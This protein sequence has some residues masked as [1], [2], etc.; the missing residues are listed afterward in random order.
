MFKKTTSLLL[1]IFL[2]FTIQAQI[3]A[4]GIAV[5]DNLE[6]FTFTDNGNK[7]SA[8]NPKTCDVDTVEFPRYKASSLVTISVSGGRSLGQLYSCPKPLTL[9]GFTFYAFVLPNPPTA[10]KMNLICRV[11][12]AGPDSLPRG[13][14]LRAD[15][16]TI[17][18]TLGG[19]V[20]TKIE[21]H[22]NW[23]AIVL[24]SNYI[25]TVETDSLNMTAG[26][27]TNNYANGDGDR[28]N[29]NCGSI[30]GLWY[31]GRNLNVGGSPFDCD[32]LLHP[33]V[34]YKLGTDFTIKSNCYNIND[35]VKFT[36]ASKNNFVGSK[37]YNRYLNFGSVSY[38]WLCHLWDL[39]DGN[40]LQYDV[41]TKTKYNTKQNYN[42]RLITTMY[43]FRGNQ[44]GCTDTTD[45]LLSYKPDIPTF[46]GNVNICKG[47]TLN[48][49]V[50]SNDPGV[51]YDWFD[52]I[53]SSKPFNTGTSYS[54]PNIGVS[55]T[56]YVRGVNNSC[57]SAFRTIQI[58]AYDYPKNLKVVNDSV[59]AG[60]KANL[61]ASSSVGQLKW[62]TQSTGGTPFYTGSVYQ[63]KALNGDT[64]FYVEAANGNCVLKPR[65]Q[66][67]V[68]VGA[69]FAPV[70]PLMSPDTIVCLG[71]GNPVVI[72][73]S[74]AP[75]LTIRWF[76]SASG[77]APVNTGNTYT[78]LP[79]KREQKSFYADAY[80]GICGSSREV[81]NLLVEK[82][83]D[84]SRVLN[85]TICK[86]D[87]AH[88]EISL[89][90]GEARW[91]DDAI[92]G[93][94]VNVADRYTY[95]PALTDTLYIETA[96]N[97]CVSPSRTQVF[98][99]VNTFPVVLKL[100]GDT[101][102]SK[103]TATLRAVLQ[104][105]GQIS[106]FDTDTGNTF[107]GSGNQFVTPVLNGGRKY[108]AQ[109]SYAGCLG[110]KVS[111][112]PTVKASPFSGFSF[113]VLTWQQVRVS[114]INAGKSRI[115]WD[116][117]DGFTST[118]NTVT[119]RYP[120]PGTYSIKL[121][122]TSNLNQC[123]DST[124]IPV[125]VE[126][127]SLNNLTTLKT[128]SVKPNPFSN[129]IEL[130]SE[131]FEGESVKVSIYNLSG[132]LVKTIECVVDAGVVSADFSELA[133]GIYLLKVDGFNP[134]KLLK[135]E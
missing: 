9:T 111:V 50:Y 62:Y 99:K 77:G 130:S 132:I 83:P 27:V 96:S 61:S 127:S 60:S 100:W 85:D 38:E 82:A 91:F 35:T 29:L 2:T 78:Y 86:G 20:L 119:H 124:I 63:T 107:L 23:P 19:G 3:K 43:G 105:A 70:A 118:A 58:N 80:N 71:T 46:S 104:G 114:P 16:I 34:R 42:I 110:P 113:E 121:V 40:G 95:F 56:M 103:N 109:T 97:I 51:S 89:P 102:C 36:N 24:D 45:K 1:T 93:N 73:A 123:K 74:A 37:M 21:K 84:I 101:I 112:Q 116:F 54:L 55:D 22:A 15:T 11:Y 32:I 5:K 41:D 31:N 87:S 49:Q 4:P 26:V 90:Y 81:V 98:A 33:H 48:L 88:L 12:K 13:L 126:E 92:G 67:D 53:T 14:P 76:T 47:D 18:S 117:G 6:K 72:R 10:K 69:D 134:M 39:G 75:G 64:T 44:F 108:Y 122:L 120:T 68:L 131:L 106:W 66:V 128:L 52:K 79:T 17:D 30:S 8:T 65:A 133:S 7:R 57:L 125:T 115:F 129:R 135:I 25:L 59:C 94:A 28:Y